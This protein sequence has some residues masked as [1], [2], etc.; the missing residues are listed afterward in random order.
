MYTRA[1][2]SEAVP[3]LAGLER[4][5]NLIRIPSEQDVP[6]TPRVRKLVDS[7]PFRRLARIRQLGL[8][9]LVYPGATHSRMEHSLGVYR[10][11]LLFLRRLTEVPDFCDFVSPAD[12]E[13]LI[14]ASLLHD[15]GHWPFCHP[16]EDLELAQVP[17]HESLARQRME[18]SEIAEILD[19][20][21]RCGVSQVMALLSGRDDS[22]SR[23]I[24]RSILSGPIDVDK[25]DY[26]YRDSLHAGVPYGMHFDRQRLIGSL[27]VNTEQW[28]LAITDKGCTAAELLVFARYVMFSEVYWHHAVRSAT[29][30]LQRV[31]YELREQLDFGR[32]F[33]GDDAEFEKALLDSV[34]GTECAEL[35]EGIFG[36]RRLLYKRVAQ[37]TV[38]DDPELFLQ[39]SRRPYPWLVRCAKCLA[40]TLSKS[41]GAPVRPHELLID[42]PPPGLEI[43]FRIPVRYENPRQFR[44]LGDVSPVVRTLADEQ[45]DNYVKRVRV[46]AHPRLA[47]R[48]RR[49]G[50]LVDTLS[51]VIAELG[52]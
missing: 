7:T 50:S 1:E 20:E 14:A 40:S 38:L 45:F 30:M 21:F 18:E 24:C 29:A 37:F 12:I 9:S 26:L 13:I 52:D 5:Q 33:A 51:R 47:E 44:W 48:I 43:Q 46:F 36:K 16:L 35:A 34:Q 3:E 8:V 41:A 11:T 15:I 27:C 32:L 6:V 39:L 19:S 49:Q 22:S 17:R 4:R 42:A 28:R 25:M 2:L 10:N 31:V 23:Q